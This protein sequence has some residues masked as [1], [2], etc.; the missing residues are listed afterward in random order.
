MDLKDYLIT[1]INQALDLVN[2]TFSSLLL[3]KIFLFTGWRS[4]PMGSI[5][6]VLKEG[7]S[8]YR[9]LQLCFLA[10]KLAYGI[11]LFSSYF[12][13]WGPWMRSWGLVCGFATGKLRDKS[14]AKSS[15]PVLSSM[16]GYKLLSPFY[17]DVSIQ[18]PKN[19]L[20]CSWTNML[21][22]LHVQLDEW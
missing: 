9:N 12:S 11:P 7:A 15:G 4:P 5:R 21:I 22:S 14:A 16:T 3:N 13:Y 20:I 1:D 18:V 2:W 19:W 8:V 17:A 6:T 10:L